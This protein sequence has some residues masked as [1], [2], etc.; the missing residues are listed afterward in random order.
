VL[1]PASQ[2]ISTVAVPRDALV[3]RSG[4]S[5]VYKLGDNN[6]AEQVSININSTVDLWVGVNN[7]IEAGDRVVIRGAERLS[8][9]QAVEVI[10]AVG[11]N[12]P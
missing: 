4:R 11:A 8:P 5:F 12:Q 3:Q 7:G 1:L 10:E 2:P 6:T 9:G